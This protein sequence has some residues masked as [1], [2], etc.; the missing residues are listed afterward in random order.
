MHV[1]PMPERPPF[2]NGLMAFQVALIP[3]DMAGGRWKIADK[4]PPLR[5][6]LK[7]RGWV[8]AK[9]EYA[10][11]ANRFERIRRSLPLDHLFLGLVHKRM[12]SSSGKCPNSR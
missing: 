7:D 10:L 9:T 5:R 12:G 8:I 4:W 1:A 2:M 3:R 6:L 11:T